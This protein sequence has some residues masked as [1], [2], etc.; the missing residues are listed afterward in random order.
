MGYRL[1]QAGYPLCICDTPKPNC[2]EYY[3]NK[4]KTCE[5]GYDLNEDFEC[6]DRCNRSENGKCVSCKD[7]TKMMLIL[8]PNICVYTPDLTPNCAVY[9]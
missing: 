6:E 2:V 7:E 3:D 9:D 1:I 5:L 4:C 8:E